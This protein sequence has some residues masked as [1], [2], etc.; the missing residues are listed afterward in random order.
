[1]L[2]LLPAAGKKCVLPRFFFFLWNDCESFAQASAVAK[3]RAKETEG[4]GILLSESQTVC[5]TGMISQST[6]SVT[7]HLT[8]PRQITLI[9]LRPLDKFECWARGCALLPAE[10]VFTSVTT[11]SQLRQEST[12]EQVLTGPGR[13]QQA[14]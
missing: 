6:V 11:F 4:K 10:G 12:S 5:V 7:V 13:R 9:D 3:Q 14:S 1:V 2:L 8:L